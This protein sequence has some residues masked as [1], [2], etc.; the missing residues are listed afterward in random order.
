MDYAAL[1]LSLEEQRIFTSLM[2]TKP[3]LISGGSE[4]T[5]AL[6]LGNQSHASNKELLQSLNIQVILQISGDI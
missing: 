6:Y 4:G 2:A 3:D 1:G 5:T